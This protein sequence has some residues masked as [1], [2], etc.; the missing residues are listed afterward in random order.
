QTAGNGLT[1]T[2]SQMNEQIMFS[3]RF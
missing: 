2:H 1:T 3:Y